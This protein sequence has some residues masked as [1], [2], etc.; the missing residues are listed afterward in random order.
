MTRR[1]RLKVPGI[2]QGGIA[3]PAALSGA[4]PSMTSRS[5]RLSVTSRACL[6]YDGGYGTRRT[7]PLAAL[8]VSIA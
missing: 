4:E 8:V 3:L 6:G 1:D 2:T 7:A 5:A